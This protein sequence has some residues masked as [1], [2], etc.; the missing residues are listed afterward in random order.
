MRATHDRSFFRKNIVSASKKSVLFPV[1]SM[2]LLG[3]LGPAATED[4]DR[5]FTAAE[6]EALLEHKRKQLRNGDQ[7]QPVVIS[8]G[9]VTTEK[10]LVVSSDDAFKMHQW[11]KQ[12]LREMCKEREKSEGQKAANYEQLRAVLRCTCVRFE[13]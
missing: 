9:F 12:L 4:A 11:Q 10:G 13:H 3:A 6:L 5:V 7:L 2:K 8:G 1:E